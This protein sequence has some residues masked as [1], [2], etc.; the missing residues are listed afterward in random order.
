MVTDAVRAAGL[1]VDFSSVLDDRS[2]QASFAGER[3][4][5]VALFTGFH[6]DYHTTG[7]IASRI[8]LPGLER[9]VDVAES[10][11]RAAADRPQ[12]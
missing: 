1:H 12:H 2:D 9:V 8:N 4:P 6:A 11:V 10:I 7:D 3:I 5:V